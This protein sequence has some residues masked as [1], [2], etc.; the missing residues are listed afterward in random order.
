VVDGKEHLAA[1]TVIESLDRPMLSMQQ[2]VNK[3]LK[4]C[5]WVMHEEVGLYI[6]ENPDKIRMVVKELQQFAALTDKQ[7]LATIFMTLMMDDASVEHL[8]LMLMTHKNKEF[9]V[10]TLEPIL[11]RNL[12]DHRAARWILKN[13]RRLRRETMQLASHLSREKVPHADE[14]L[15]LSLVVWMGG[16]IQ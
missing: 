3:L 11:I 13:I 9:L 10:C 4:I 6:R 16:Q 1:I 14:Y 15:D 5:P 8:A 2:R 12:L 7:F